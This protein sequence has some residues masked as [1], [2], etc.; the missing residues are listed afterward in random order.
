MPFRGDHTLGQLGPVSGM[1]LEEVLPLR[2]SYGKWVSPDM[3]EGMVATSIFNTSFQIS[4]LHLY[5]EGP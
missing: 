5:V 2:K 4:W 3:T 1:L